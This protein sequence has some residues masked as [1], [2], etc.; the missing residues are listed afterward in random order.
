M[1]YSEMYMTETEIRKAALELPTDQ[2]R[3]LGL[4]LV[5]STLPELTE[6]QVRLVD[7]RLNEDDAHPDAALSQE[8]FDSELDKRLSNRA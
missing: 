1:A 7:H 5:E 2:R 6:E 8:D 3:Q 4:D